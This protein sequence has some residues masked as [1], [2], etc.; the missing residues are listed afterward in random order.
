MIKLVEIID[1]GVVYDTTGDWTL[2][3]SII[4]ILTYKY[5]GLST[6][7]LY[8]HKDKTYD[9]TYIFEPRTTFLQLLDLVCLEPNNDF[10]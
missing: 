6:I 4:S 9:N 7:H 5:F 2:L 8:H 3:K 10:Y 1:V